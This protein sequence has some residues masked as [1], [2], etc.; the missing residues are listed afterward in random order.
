MNS[1]IVFSCLLALASAAP[2][3]PIP[4]P[5]CPN[6]PFCGIG[7]NELAHAT[8]AQR[9]VLQ[10]QFAISQPLVPN[11]PGLDAHFAAEAEV[12]AAQGRVPGFPLHSFAEARVL[13]AE[14]DLIAVQQL[15]Y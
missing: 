11:V 3:G 10:Q 12:L 6:Y 5:I 14:A 1:F 9:R 8:D 13:Q 4:S 15:Q 2:S 7:P